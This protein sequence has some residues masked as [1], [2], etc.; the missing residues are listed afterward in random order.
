MFAKYDLKVQKPDTA[1]YLRIDL[2]ND[3]Y[4]L[5]NMR[6]KLIDKTDMH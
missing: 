3:K 2:P 1:L 6:I 4:L 5:R